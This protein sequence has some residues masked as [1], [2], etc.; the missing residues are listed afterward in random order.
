MWFLILAGAFIMVAL[1]VA[2]LARLLGPDFP[3]LM[4]LALG[5]PEPRS[6]TKHP[7]VRSH[8]VGA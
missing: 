3:F 4:W 7:K 8:K 1:L 5:R 6:A 2:A